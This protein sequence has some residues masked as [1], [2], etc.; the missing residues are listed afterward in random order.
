MAHGHFLSHQQLDQNL[1]ETFSLIPPPFPT[2][3]GSFAFHI[4]LFQE[5]S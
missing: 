2:S 3:P 1:V 4:D 5:D